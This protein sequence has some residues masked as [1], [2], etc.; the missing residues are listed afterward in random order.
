M[1]NNLTCCFT[2]H[3]PN[4]LGGYDWNTQKNREI[5]K[6]LF[7]KIIELIKNQGI[8]K[9]IFGGALGTDQLAFAICEKIKKIHNLNLYLILALP[10]DNLD[11]KWFNKDRQ[12]LKHQRNL[13]N[14]VILV[15]ELKDKRYHCELNG[16]GNYHISKMQ[17]RNK[18]M[19]DNSTHII[20]VWNGTKGGTA[21]CLN[22]A[23]R[24]HIASSKQVWI[25]DPNSLKIDMRYC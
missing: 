8:K 6:V 10:F 22:Y 16:L 9:F 4:K 18:F 13:A 14:E 25:I 11:I 17:N 23:F 21:N 5:A 24:N 19:I 2:G 20:A 12:R 7:K 3:R 15:D 1:E